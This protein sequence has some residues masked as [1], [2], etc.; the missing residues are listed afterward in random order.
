MRAT[1]A[2]A[3][4]TRLARYTE[5]MTTTPRKT[6]NRRDYHMA[7]TLMPALEESVTRELA[8]LASPDPERTP[9]YPPLADMLGD[10][11][12]RLR[13]GTREDAA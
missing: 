6:L 11:L 3:S 4:T 10:A 9:A 13:A 5:Y 7:R 12:A 8:Y 2:R 1:H